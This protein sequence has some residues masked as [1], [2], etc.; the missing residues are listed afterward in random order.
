M[1]SDKEFLQEVGKRTKKH[2][3]KRFRFP[4]VLSGNVGRLLD[5]FNGDD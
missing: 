4:Q 1:Q 5:Y 2:K 3:K